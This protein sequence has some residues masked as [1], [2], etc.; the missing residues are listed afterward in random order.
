MAFS[1][2][3]KLITA[4]ALALSSASAHAQ[5]EPT[6]AQDAVTEFQSCMN[7][8]V[9]RGWKTENRP[10]VMLS[11]N[12]MSFRFFA[13]N[14]H[15]EKNG[16]TYG[17]SSDFVALRPAERYFHISAYRRNSVTDLRKTDKKFDAA[18]RDYT[19]ANKACGDSKDVSACFKEKAPNIA[20]SG[21]K[22]DVFF[23]FSGNTRYWVDI[24]E[25][26]GHVLTTHSVSFKGRLAP[27][28]A[29]IEKATAGNPELEKL[30]PAAA[31]LSSCVRPVVDKFLKLVY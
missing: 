11:T 23:H 9:K 27:R 29:D 30:V 15:I 6:A 10:K 19:E 13:P 7:T 21:D 26:E 31:T 12:N 14:Y 17:I 24:S 22:T 4:A 16:V 28:R 2:P 18:M 5:V 8:V 3:R 25:A 20:L 1:L